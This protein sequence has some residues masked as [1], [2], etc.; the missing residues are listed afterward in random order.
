M[1]SNRIVELIAHE[2]MLDGT[3][4]EALFNNIDMKNLRLDANNFSGRLSSAI[5]DLLNLVE[6]RLGRN[7]F[8]G[9]LP[10]SLWK[11]TKLRKYKCTSAVS[12]KSQRQFL[13][14]VPSF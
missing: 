9:S 2:N 3:I 13:N 1:G 5:G 6:L 8:S 7:K 4:P 11:L 10:S 14:V 12:F